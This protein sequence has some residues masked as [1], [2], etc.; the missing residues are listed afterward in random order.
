MAT[1]GLKDPSL[2]SLVERDATAGA[3]LGASKL[4][5]AVVK[6]LGGGS[7][8]QA[9]YA[10]AASQAGSALAGKAMPRIKEE[11]R[12]MLARGAASLRKKFLGFQSGGR[13]YK[14]F[15]KGGKCKK[16]SKKRKYMACFKK[17]DGKLVKFAYGG[18][19]RRM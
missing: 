6:K 19:V 5:G 10:R 8:K 15:C 2:S 13:V 1:V 11:G 16:S 17:K 14:A 7:K 12:K 18:K 3:A 9:E 4:A